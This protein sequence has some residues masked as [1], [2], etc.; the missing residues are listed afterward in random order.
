VKRIE[1]EESVVV[2]IDMDHVKRYPSR[3]NVITRTNKDRPR[4]CVSMQIPGV[5]GKNKYQVVLWSGSAS[6]DLSI[7][8]PGVV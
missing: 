7:E 5:N 3:D 4:P 2:K 6:N 8:F 1:Q